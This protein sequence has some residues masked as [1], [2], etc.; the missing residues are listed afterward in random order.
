MI[1]IRKI[2]DDLQIENPSLLQVADYL[3]DSGVSDNTY[4]AYDDYQDTDENDCD[5]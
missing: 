3:R 2:A 4:V 5:N 1:S